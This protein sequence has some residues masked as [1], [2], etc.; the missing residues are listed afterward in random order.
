MRLAQSTQRVVITLDRDF[1]RPDITSVR[2]RPGIIYLNLPTRRRYVPDIERLLSDFFANHAHVI[3]LKHTII[4][5]NEE[6]PS[7]LS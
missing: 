7:I 1:I 2:A 6:G 3:D 5:L 4:V